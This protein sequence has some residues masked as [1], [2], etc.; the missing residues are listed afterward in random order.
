MSPV[1]K[2]MLA[3]ESR[4]GQHD[5]FGGFH[6][7]FS[8]ECLDHFA[9]QAEGLAVEVN[10]DGEPVGIVTAAERSPEG[11]RTSTTAS[12]ATTPN[13]LKSPVPPGWAEPSMHTLPKAEARTDGSSSSPGG[14]RC[15]GMVAPSHP[16]DFRPPRDGHARRA[17]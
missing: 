11:V 4:P 7:V 10:F 9:E 5:A 8:P 16:R 14:E 2:A 15:E 17:Q 1:I 3:T 6:Y 12:G 13:P